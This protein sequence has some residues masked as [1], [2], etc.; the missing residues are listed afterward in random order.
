MSYL[1]LGFAAS[2]AIIILGLA[3]TAFWYRGNAI[4]AEAEAAQARLDLATAKAVNK[5]N[6]E[7]LGRLKAQQEH[8]ADLAAR[9]AEQL[10]ETNDALNTANDE[11]RKAERENE[12]ARKFLGLRI[13]DSLRGVPVSPKAN[14]PD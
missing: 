1:R 9:L 10:A 8:D 11:R 13:P 14:G 7:A 6:E 3:T 2:I 5:A 4:A 12:D